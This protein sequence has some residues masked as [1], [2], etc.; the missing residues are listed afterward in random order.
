MNSYE[1]PELQRK[2]M[3]LFQR[4]KDDGYWKE[5][6]ADK[7]FEDL[8]SELLTHVEKCIDHLPGGDLQK[9]W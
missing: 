9:L 1:V 6:D 4:L 5:I 2:V 8:Q 7:S 3:K